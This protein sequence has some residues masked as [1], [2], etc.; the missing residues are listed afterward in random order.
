M[1]LVT[2]LKSSEITEELINNPRYLLYER[3]DGLFEVE[4]FETAENHTVSFVADSDIIFHIYTPERPGGK[5]AC[6]N[7][8]DCNNLKYFHRGYTQ[9]QPSNANHSVNRFQ[10][11]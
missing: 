10:P 11:Q 6:V 2:L 1:L 8:L 4:D 9:S 5:F 3:E 7:L